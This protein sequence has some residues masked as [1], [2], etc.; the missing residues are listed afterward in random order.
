MA[1]MCI[2]TIVA[3]WTVPM[4]TTLP[5][6]CG[7]SYQSFNQD[8]GTVP[9][10]GCWK[11]VCEVSGGVLIWGKRA[12]L[13]L[14]APHSIHWGDTGDN[15]IGMQGPRDLLQNHAAGGSVG[16]RAVCCPLRRY[17]S[18]EVIVTNTNNHIQIGERGQDLQLKDLQWK[19]VSS[20]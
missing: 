17:R 9:L 7:G 1:I 6:R 4:Q 19:N 12:T 2:R 10:R 14:G 18:R 3:T 5:G 16:D 11:A 13:E 15:T 20:R 8:R